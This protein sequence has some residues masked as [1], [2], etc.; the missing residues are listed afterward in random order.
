LRKL[1]C[2]LTPRKT[3]GGESVHKFPM[4]RSRRLLLAARPISLRPVEE[5]PSSL[6]ERV[7]L[8]HV[9]ADRVQNTLMQSNILYKYQQPNKNTTKLRPQPNPAHQPQDLEASANNCLT[10]PEVKV[11]VSC[12]A[13]RAT[14]NP[15]VSVIGSR[16]R[17]P[18]P[19]D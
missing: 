13:S 6:A 17:S 3:F 19:V 14:N 2:I 8:G 9:K 12:P 16:S 15:I 7:W 4:A 5:L 1:S 10:N 18:S 11:K